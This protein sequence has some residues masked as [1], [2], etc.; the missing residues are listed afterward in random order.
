MIE[1]F[2]KISPLQILDKSSRKELGKG[3]LGVLMARAGVGKT[4]CLIHIAFD[5]LLRQEKLVHISLADGPEKVTSYYNVI[6]YDFVKALGITSEQDVRIL[7][8]QNRMILAYLN[9]SFK[10]DRLREN[11]QNLVQHI[12]FRPRSL[13]VDGLDFEQTDRETLNGFK[14]VAGEFDA[15]VWFSAMAHRHVSRKNERGIPYPLHELDD[16]FDIILHLQPDP[17]GVHLNLLKDHEAYL[18][19]P[20]GIKIDPNTFLALEDKG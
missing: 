1:D 17:S 12:G 2:S 9:R 10:I 8:E 20:E 4:A 16:L 18:D 14:E 13:I 7:I 6:F 5:R 11:L 19:P 3:N 15:E